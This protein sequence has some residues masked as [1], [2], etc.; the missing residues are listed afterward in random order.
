MFKHKNY[1]DNETK[2]DKLIACEL[3]NRISSFFIKKIHEK[4]LKFHKYSHC[5]GAPTLRVRIFRGF[6][7]DYFKTL[8]SFAGKQ[9]SS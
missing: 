6:V 3:P 2:M 5:D 4:T 9:K 1:F 8:K 7:L